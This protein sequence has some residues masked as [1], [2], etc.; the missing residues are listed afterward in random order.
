MGLPVSTGQPADNKEAAMAATRIKRLAASLALAAIGGSGATALVGEADAGAAVTYQT[1]ASPSL[2]ARSGPGTGYAAIRSLPRGTNISIVCQVQN[3]TSV[4]GSRTWDRLSD[5]TWVSDYWTNT[6]SYNSYIPGIGDCGSSG[7]GST[8]IPGASSAISWA[9]ARVGSTA[10]EGWCERFVANAYGRSTAGFASAKAHWND[11]VARGR[12]RT[13][14]NPPA[15]ALVFWNSWYQGVNYGHVGIS[16]G[17]GNVI[18]TSVYGRV[19]TTSLGHFANYL[20]WVSPY[21]G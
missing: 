1:T 12:A 11:A 14:R 10:W 15:G 7:G 5:G 13:D 19:G 8:S 3:G 9:R 18:A 2:T 16:L 20:G 17:S 21:F 4:G 6:P